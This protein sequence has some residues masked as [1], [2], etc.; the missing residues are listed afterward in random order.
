M[1]GARHVLNLQGP[2][3][4]S[5]LKVKVDLEKFRLD[6]LPLKSKIVFTKINTFMYQ[7]KCHLHNKPDK[8]HFS[9]FYM[10]LF[11]C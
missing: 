4:Q 9:T 5:S 6:I 10:H 1:G 3:L 11:R 2:E 7:I 8:F